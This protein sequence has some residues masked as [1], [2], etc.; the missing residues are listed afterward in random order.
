M[1]Q[2]T[3]L[4][5]TVILAAPR[6]RAQPALPDGAFRSVPP[7]QIRAQPRDAAAASA[8]AASAWRL[9]S[10]TYPSGVS[11]VGDVD[12]RAGYRQESPDVPFRGNILYLEGLG[13]SLR[14]HEPLFS[15]LCAAG[16]RVIAFDYMGQGGSD[17]T[18][19]D[20]R[21]IDPVFP[22]LQISAVADAVWS[23]YRRTGSPAGG[24]KVV[25]GWSTGGL[26]AYLMAG[27]GDADA[28]ILIAPGIV[29]RLIVGDRLKITE[30]TLTSA[31]YAPGDD[32][33]V[34]PIRPD[35]PAEVPLFAANL[36]A[37][38]QLARRRTMPAAVK[39]LVL[40]SGPSDAYVDAAKTQQVLSENAPR[41]SAVVYPGAL[42]EIDNEVPSIRAALTA[43]V[44]GFL[45]GLD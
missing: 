44:L 24:R 35:S 40:L 41:F 36:L 33:N 21:I 1:L 13:D 26:A 10:F 30:S 7:A 15:Q 28:V 6:A 20:T 2:R 11:F 42:H 17:G 29:P 31:R 32:P 16:Y 39:G 18:M 8:A 14:D 43:A 22:S 12:L 25:L 5:A 19:D 3:I 45:N 34:D 23:K 27:A 9:E 4:L 37:S 38:S